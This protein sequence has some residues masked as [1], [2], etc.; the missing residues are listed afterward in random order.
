MEQEKK[1]IKGTNEESKNNVFVKFSKEDKIYEFERIFL[2]GMLDGG[3]KEELSTI[4]SGFTDLQDFV[5][6]FNNLLLQAYE[7]LVDN[8]END[9][10]DV[11]NALRENSLQIFQGIEDG[12][13]DSYFEE[14]VNID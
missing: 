9:K 4:I 12:A 6:I 5:T 3:G 1:T 14:T 7:F 11:I 10:D 2:C 13:F 8:A